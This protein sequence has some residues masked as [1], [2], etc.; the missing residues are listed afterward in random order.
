MFPTAGQSY[1]KG[2]VPQPGT[3]ALSWGRR[4]AIWLGTELGNVQRATAR[5]SSRTVTVATT[6]T[7]TDDVILA[8][9]TGG[10]FT[11]TLPDPTTV[12]EAVFT[13]KRLNGGGNAVTIGGTVDGTV[14]P[15]LGSQ[16]ASMTVKAIGTNDSAAWY[17]VAEL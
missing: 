6:A 4:L 17:K 8:N 12:L 1:T 2:A 5:A 16:Y 13:V 15:S 9:A 3:D 14:N 7:I 11:V 10:A